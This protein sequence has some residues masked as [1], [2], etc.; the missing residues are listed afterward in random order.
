[1][2][3][4]DKAKNLITIKELIE[5]LQQYPGHYLALLSSEF[6]TGS[7]QEWF[8]PR[9]WLFCNTDGQGIVAITEKIFCGNPSCMECGT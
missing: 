9:T 7:D 4:H 5:Q 8:T 2:E 1:M 3:T 6:Q